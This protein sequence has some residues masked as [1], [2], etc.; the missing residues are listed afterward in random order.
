MLRII[1]TVAFLVVL[2]G[3]AAIAQTNTAGSSGAN[4][5]PQ[6]S[7][8]SAPTGHRQPTRTE[9]PAEDGKDGISAIDAE[10]KALDRKLKS[11]CRGC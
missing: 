8:P 7:V 6:T 3:T 9:V 11:I 4:N 2:C 5:K 1:T 10:D